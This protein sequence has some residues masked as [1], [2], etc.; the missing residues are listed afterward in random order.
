MRLSLTDTNGESPSTHRCSRMQPQFEGSLCLIIS[1]L[2][3]PGRPQPSCM[4]P[5]SASF[6]V[7]AVPPWISLI[8]TNCSEFSDNI[9]SLKLSRLDASTLTP[10]PLLSI[11]IPAT[12]IPRLNKLAAGWLSKATN[13]S[14]EVGLREPDASAAVVPRIRCREE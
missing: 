8:S 3:L 9:A 7:L 6:V 12:D 10:H 2:R 11:S 4:P 13:L 5:L 1:T 14:I